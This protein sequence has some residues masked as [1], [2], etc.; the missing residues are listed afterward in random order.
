MFAVIVYDIPSDEK[1]TKR[2]N[3]VRKL[4]VKYGY[5][6]QNSVFEMT[7]DYGQLLK[8]ENDIC[9]IIDSAVDSVRVYNIGKVRTDTNVIVLGRREVCE[10]SDTCFML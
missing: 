5:H 6:V 10:S 9:K 4:C 3:K 2:G 8:I 7:V 1:G